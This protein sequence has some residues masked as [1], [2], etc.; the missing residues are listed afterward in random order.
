M[1]LVIREQELY[2]LHMDQCYGHRV[3]ITRN[4]TDTSGSLILRYLS[5]SS[6]AL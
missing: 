3:S 2:V 5:I 1:D 6:K 4:G